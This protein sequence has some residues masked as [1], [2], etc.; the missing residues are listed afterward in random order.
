MGEGGD[1]VR[2]VT[3]KGAGVQETVARP[4]RL[5]CVVERTLALTVS[6]VGATEEF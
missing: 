4:C 3:A 5:L 6:E 2:V 1:K